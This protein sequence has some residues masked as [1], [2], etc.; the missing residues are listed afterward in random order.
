MTASSVGYGDITVEKQENPTF[1]VRFIAA[2]CL[3]LIGSITYGNL[4]AMVRK[5][6]NML[7]SLNEKLEEEASLV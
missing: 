4:Y 2:I 7:T 6:M 3:L 1:R 5:T